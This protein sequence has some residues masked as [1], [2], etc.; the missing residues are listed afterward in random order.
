MAFRININMNKNYILNLVSKSISYKNIFASL[1]LFGAFFFGCKKDP[2][3]N[4]NPLAEESQS[5]F[6][7]K[8]DIYPNPCQG[9]FTIKPNTSDS[10][11]V[12][13]FNMSGTE[14]FSLTINGTTSI[15]DKNLVS[16]IYL[17]TISSKHGTNSNKIIVSK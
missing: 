10:Q 2:L 17:I 4:S 11:Y 7:L 15:V 12:K 14:I 5:L 9:I 13:L 3:V 6:V 16:G 8:N 1:L